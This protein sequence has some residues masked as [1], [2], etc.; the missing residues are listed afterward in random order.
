MNYRQWNTKE[1]EKHFEEIKQ[2]FLKYGKVEIMPGNIC[3]DGMVI[4]SEGTLR[5]Y[6]HVLFGWYKG[7]KV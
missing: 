7:E 5:A 1:F 2:D 4:D 6:K 3:P